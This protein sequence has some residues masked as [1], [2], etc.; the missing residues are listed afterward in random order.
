V[1][2][3][4]STFPARFGSFSY[5]LFSCDKDYLYTFVSVEDNNS[6]PLTSG[7][8]GLFFEDVESGYLDG[9]VLNAE[10]F[11]FKSFLIEPE[12]FILGNA[13]NLATTTTGLNNDWQCSSYRNVFDD[14][15]CS[16]VTGLT[17]GVEV[18]FWGYRS[19]G[20]NHVW[21]RT[22][23][24]NSFVLE[25]PEST[26]PNSKCGLLPPGDDPEEFVEPE[27]LMEDA[28]FARYIRLVII[29]ILACL[30]VNCCCCCVCWCCKAKKAASAA[31]LAKDEEKEKEKKRKEEIEL[32]SSTYNP[33]M[34][35]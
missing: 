15:H 19:D 6:Q 17:P 32:H 18:N 10:D 7:M 8:R 34:M 3:L 26:A 35:Q 5:E 30:V 14:V 2:E 31:A 9:W 22:S 29:I 13:P 27:I 12:D 21:E 25:G 4:G 28:K 16:R 1:L 20:R 23:N 33:N 24:G 11:T